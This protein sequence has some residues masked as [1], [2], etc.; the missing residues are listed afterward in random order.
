MSEEGVDKAEFR[1]QP[2]GE[3]LK[4]ARESR[5]L[6]LGDIATQTRVPMRHLEAIEAA[7]YSATAVR[8]A[9][10]FAEARL[11]HGL[12]LGRQGLNR[13]AAEQFREALRRKPGLLD[14]RLNL[15][16][17]LLDQNPAEALACFEEVLRQNPAHATAQ[18]YAQRARTKVAG[19]GP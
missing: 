9:P 15:G 18:K 2:V 1:F 6:T 11:L 8:L 10:E 19:T 7:N 5:G 16:I 3:Q 14:A 13:E 4:S 17:A 12:V